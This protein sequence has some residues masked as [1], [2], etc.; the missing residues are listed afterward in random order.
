MRT[1]SNSVPMQT[2]F[3]LRLIEPKIENMECKLQFTMMKGS[4][5]P[6]PDLFYNLFE[7]QKGS[8]S[9]K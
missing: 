6:L 2:S 5:G 3:F 1:G 4:V 8:E 9:F 7:A